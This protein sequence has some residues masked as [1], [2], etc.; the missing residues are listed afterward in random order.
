[1]E[2]LTLEQV[3]ELEG[4]SV[5]CDLCPSF[6]LKIREDTIEVHLAPELDG[7]RWACADEEV[8][9]RLQKTFIRLVGNI[10]PI[11]ANT[12]RDFKTGVAQALTREAQGGHLFRVTD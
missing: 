4:P 5:Y 6:I 12:I 1:M 10:E 11:S 8:K 7:R 9:R 3:L 2:D